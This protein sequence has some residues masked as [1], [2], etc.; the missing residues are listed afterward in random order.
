MQET[1][2]KSIGFDLSFND[3]LAESNR[4]GATVTDNFT[5]GLSYMANFIGAI[6]YTYMALRIRIPLT[7]LLNDIAKLNICLE[8]PG[9][10]EKISSK[11]KMIHI[12]LQVTLAFL[13]LGFGF[14][15]ANVLGDFSSKPVI[16]GVIFAGLWMHMIVFRC[17][18]PCEITLILLVIHLSENVQ[19][20]IKIFREK[21]ESNHC[22][23][24]QVS[25]AGANLRNVFKS[26]NSTFSGFIFAETFL[27]MSIL[28][29]G[30]KIKPSGSCN[31][32]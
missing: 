1:I 7:N 23:I 19:E 4:L 28:T 30:N 15:F 10:D 27:S 11:F 26:M 12:G 25:N 3:I 17:V 29:I 9:P 16:N 6:L 14:A 32:G 20:R 22:T 2:F 21:L 24:E 31:A 8:T 13:L 18:L 5:L